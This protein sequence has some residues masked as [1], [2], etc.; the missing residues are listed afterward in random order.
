M[1]SALRRRTVLGG[2]LAG[3]VALAAGA[4]EPLASADPQQAR[5]ELRTVRR[6]VAAEHQLIAGYDAVRQRHPS[7]AGRLDPLAKE[8]ADHVRALLERIRP[9]PSPSSSS[10]PAPSTTRAASPPGTGGASS[11][12]PTSV[13]DDPDDAVKMLAAREQDAFDARMDDLV[14][15]PSFL[16]QLLSAIGASEATHAATL[17]D[18]R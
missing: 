15:A 10:N 5:P 17:D 9:T 3:A 12:A 1:S 16:A 2:S 11:P 8:H 18:R 4:C 13:P 6:V 7:L 14:D